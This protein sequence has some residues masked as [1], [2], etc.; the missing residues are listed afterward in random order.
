MFPI[1]IEF[2]RS[3]YIL[4]LKKLQLGV[5]VKLKKTNTIKMLNKLRTL[6]KKKK[7]QTYSRST[8]VYRSCT[9][10]IYDLRT[11]NIII[12]IFLIVIIFALS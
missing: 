8:V 11:F 3:K 5:V 7:I 6:S 9:Y 4:S 10:R 12:R 1:N 2:N